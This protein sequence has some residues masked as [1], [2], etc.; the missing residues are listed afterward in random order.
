MA[1]S[2]GRNRRLVY[3]EEGRHVYGGQVSPDG[4]YVVFTDNVQEVAD[5]RHAGAAMRL[6]RLADAPIIGGE[7]P[8][9]SEAAS[10][11]ETRT[12]P[13]STHGMG[14]LLDGRRDRSRLN[15]GTLIPKHPHGLVDIHRP[16]EAKI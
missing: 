10:G 6:L 13:E 5:P 2:E 12:G 1:D 3:G 14:A 4:K 9:A 16:R 8:R 7:S 15:L 11:G